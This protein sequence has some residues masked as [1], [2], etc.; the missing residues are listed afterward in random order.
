[1][2]AIAN[3]VIFFTILLPSSLIAQWTYLGLGDKTGTKIELV[4]N[5][6]YVGTTNGFFKKELYNN[7]TAW[8]ALGLEGKEITDFVIFNTDTILVSTYV[9]AP[10]LV[11]SQA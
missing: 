5:E 4:E 2:K 6:I 10:A 1:M 8:T 11:S 9:A 3:L 7:D